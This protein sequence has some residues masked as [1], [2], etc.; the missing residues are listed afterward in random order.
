MRLAWD[1]TILAGN[2]HNTKVKLG[3][4][5]LML[6]SSRLSCIDHVSKCSMK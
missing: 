3:L 1:Y 2:K 4:V 6:D 5:K